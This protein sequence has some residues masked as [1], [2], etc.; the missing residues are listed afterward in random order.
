VRAG[1]H[2]RT[3]QI[4]CPKASGEGFNT[5]ALQIDP[6]MVL[7][8]VADAGINMGILC[9]VEAYGEWFMLL[10]PGTAVRVSD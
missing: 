3:Y 10:G 7:S 1:K 5:I 4:K 2:G 6:D 9:Q 8:E